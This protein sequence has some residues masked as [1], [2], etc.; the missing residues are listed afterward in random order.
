MLL[1]GVSVNTFT[2]ALSAA[3]ESTHTTEAAVCEIGYALPSCSLIKSKP[4]SRKI[5]SVF[6]RSIF[7]YRRAHKFACLKVILGDCIK[8]QDITP[9]VACHKYLFQ[10]LR[11][12]SQKTV[13][14]ISG[15]FCFK[16]TA[17]AIPEAPP[18][19]TATEII[20]SS[21]AFKLHFA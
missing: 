4:I 3:D 11:I 16:A 17:N 1:T 8:I 21:P 13:T 20:Y 15:L 9:A 14:S 18:P 2:P 7:F 12:F 10:H 5:A 19:I 6:F